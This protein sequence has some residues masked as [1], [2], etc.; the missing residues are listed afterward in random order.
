M[1]MYKKNQ[2]VGSRLVSECETDRVFFDSEK[3]KAVFNAQ[4]LAWLLGLL[5]GPLGKPL[6]LS[7]EVGNIQL[8]TNYIDI[9]C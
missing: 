6:G 3:T 1:R 2:Q 7:F 8:K 9:I 4:Q 5:N